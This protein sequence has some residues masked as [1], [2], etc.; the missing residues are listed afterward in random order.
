MVVKP[1]RINSLRNKSFDLLESWAYAVADSGSDEALLE[2]VLIEFV[3]E[4]NQIPENKS[5]IIYTKKRMRRVK[6]ILDKAIY[7]HDVYKNISNLLRIFG[8]N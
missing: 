8:I 4:L 1:K 2:Y 6:K 7:S 3:K 5:V